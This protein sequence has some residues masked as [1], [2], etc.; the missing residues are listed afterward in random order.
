MKL[1]GN[2]DEEELQLTH[3][4]WVIRVGGRRILPDRPIT[5]LHDMISIFEIYARQNPDTAVDV[6]C[7]VV[8]TGVTA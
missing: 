3:R 5:A 7:R 2:G 1:G 8:K 6:S 4:E